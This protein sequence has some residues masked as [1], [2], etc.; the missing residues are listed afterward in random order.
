MGGAMRQLLGLLGAINGRPRERKKKMVV[1]RRPVQA[2]E[3]RVR[4]DCERCERE[5]KKAL[6][7]MRG[8]QHVEVNR[9]QQKVTVTGE[10]DPLAVLRLA[11]STGKKAEPWPHQNAAAAGGGGYC[12]APAAVALYGI[13]AAQLQAHDGGR[14]ANPAGYYHHPPARSVEA[15]AIIGADQITNLFSDDNPNACSLM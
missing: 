15:A 7:G 9:L 12:Y 10:V 3:L 5:V 11:Q 8:V 6:S 4:M 14:W 13:G 2:V 1:P